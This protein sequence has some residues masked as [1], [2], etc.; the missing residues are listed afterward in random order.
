MTVYVWV[1]VPVPSLDAPRAAFATARAQGR[2]YVI[3]GSLD[4]EPLTSVR[5]LAPYALTNTSHEASGMHQGWRVESPLPF[6]RR[7]CA[8]A[9]WRGAGGQ[10]RG[11]GHGAQ[12]AVFVLG[13][14]GRFHFADRS[15]AFSRPPVL[16]A[17]PCSH[18]SCSDLRVLYFIC[19]PICPAAVVSTICPMLVSRATMQSIVCG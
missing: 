6:A 7:F 18:I 17:R 3:G 11:N 1:N 19:S 9:S 4:F 5:S 14:A 12:E 15:L 13:G 10:D 16:R 8:A 2:I